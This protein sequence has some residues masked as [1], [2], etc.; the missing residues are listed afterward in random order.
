MI[1]TVSARFLPRGLR[2]AAQSRSLPFTTTQRF[3]R[4]SSVLN[5][6]RTITTYKL[7]T[8]ATIPAL[9]FGTWQDVDA[10]EQAVSAAIKVRRSSSLFSD[11]P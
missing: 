8:G 10:Q 1:A 7:N 3:W 6:V 5:G 11:Q 4:D 2:L 9:G